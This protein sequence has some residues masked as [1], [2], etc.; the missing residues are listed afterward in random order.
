MLLTFRFNRCCTRGAQELRL[1]LPIA[2]LKKAKQQLAP[3][4]RSKW[5]VGSGTSNFQPRCFAH[6]A[7]CEN[8][9]C[10]VRAHLA[11]SVSVDDRA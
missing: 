9:V 2:S 6:V 11:M 10:T 8:R 7:V 5:K 4:G 1:L 3:E